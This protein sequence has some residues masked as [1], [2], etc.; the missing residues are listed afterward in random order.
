[1]P[2]GIDAVHGARIQTALSEWF[3]ASR[4]TLPWRSEPR[5]PYHVWLSEVMLQ[6]T[7]VA[8]VV[9]YFHRWLER[10][11]TLQALADA[12]LDDVLKHWEGLGYYARARNFHKAARRVVQLHNGQLPGN[13]DALLE[14][15]GVGRYTAGAVASLAFGARAAALDGNVKRV[16]SRVFAVTQPD[17]DLWALAE[18]LLPEENAGAHNE[19]L[20]ELGATVCT[21]R[22]PRCDACPLHA[23]CLARAEGAPGRY[24]L[25]KAKPVTPHHNVLCAV[26]S[27]SEGDLLLCQRPP[28][29]LLGGLWEFVSG[30]LRSTPQAIDVASVAAMVLERTGLRVT[31]TAGAPLTRIKHAFTHFKITKHVFACACDRARPE[32]NLSGYAAAGWFTRAEIEAL[33]LAR[34]DRRLL[35]YS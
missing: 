13:V 23:L 3:R 28:G 29:G 17:A 34:S 7:Q 14:L 2:K 6:Q 12:P 32:F 35:G 5:D 15:P 24:P 16:L 8:T 18:A 31:V 10:F 33:A 9:P 4:R 26:V 30:D 25:R 11:P 1:V 19:A 20:M 22:N 21:A 27:D